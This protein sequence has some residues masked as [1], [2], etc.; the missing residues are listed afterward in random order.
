[1]KLSVLICTRD[2]AKSLEATL[3]TLFAQ[4]FAGDYEYEVLIIDNA[5]SDDTRE[6]IGRFENAHPGSIRY[7]FAPIPG[8]SRA[9]NKAMGAA[10]GDVVVFTDDDVLVN[11]DW[12]DEIASEF[13]RDPELQM[14]GGRVMPAREDLQKVALQESTERQRFVHPHGG[15]FVMGANMAFRRELFDRIGRFD[16]RLGAGSFFAGAEDADIFYRG[17]KAGFTVLY[18]PNVVVY[19]DHRRVTVEQACR[20][21][22]GYGKGCSAY[23]VKHALRG[24]RYAMRMVYW[25]IYR[26]PSR[27]RRVNARSSDVLQRRRAQIRGILVGLMFA[28]LVMWRKSE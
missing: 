24:D 11:Y 10:T 14:L 7:L 17:L 22:Y 9:R 3:E 15:T 4:C 12:L 19:H 8:L 27:W 21:E 28:P 2:R 6:V 20:L 5:S 18:A 23:L 26:L 1:M 16:V 13:R 25:L